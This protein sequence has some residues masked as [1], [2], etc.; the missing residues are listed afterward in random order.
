VTVRVAG[1]VIG[2]A[3]AGC[4]QDAPDIDV[5]DGAEVATMAERELMAQNPRMAPGTLACPDLEFKVG[6]SVRCLRT[7]ELS[8]GRVV[9]VA[10][11]VEVTSRDSGGR[12]HVAMDDE[13]AEFGL[14]GDQLASELA[15]RYTRAGKGAVVECPYL[16]GTVGHQ[17]TCQV[18]ISGARRDVVTVVTAV[19]EQRYDV[20]YETR[21]RRA[22]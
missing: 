13:A 19:D 3:L 4:G 8:G 5:L 9:K 15:A 11:S 6:E 10:G 22:N 12:L 17:V 16:R 14:A 2:L 20:D 1:L 21:R 18:D 7:T